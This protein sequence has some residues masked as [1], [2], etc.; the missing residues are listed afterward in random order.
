M[1]NRAAPLLSKLAQWAKCQSVACPFSAEYWHM[2]ATTVRLASVNGPRGEVRV[3]SENKWL[4]ENSR[5]K[6]ACA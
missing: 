1:M 5:N 2:G 4:T 3:N 6:K